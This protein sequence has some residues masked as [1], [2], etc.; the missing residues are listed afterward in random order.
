MEMCRKLIGEG[1]LS[2]PGLD[3]SEEGRTKRRR[4]DT[5]V[6]D[7]CQPPS[8]DVA[9]RRLHLFSGTD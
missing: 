7:G 4:V 3:G 5:Q 2:D 8:R 9:G 6:R 1:A